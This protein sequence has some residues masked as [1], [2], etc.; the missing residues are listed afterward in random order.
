L[1]ID[2][3]R[4]GYV[5]PIEDINYVYEDELYTF[6]C[7]NMI[8]S[9][10]DEG[11]FPNELA[12][13]DFSLVTNSTADSWNQLVTSDPATVVSLQYAHEIVLETLYHNCRSL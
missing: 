7:N 11:Y 3:V 12:N 4:G 2:P 8:P 10:L 1:A 9:S 6:K 5:F 13:G